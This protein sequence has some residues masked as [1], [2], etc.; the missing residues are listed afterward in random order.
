MHE[1]K[2]VFN[3]AIS[4]VSRHL[5]DQCVEKFEGDRRTKILPCWQQFLV[6]VFGQLGKRESLRDLC[7][8]LHA[9]QK[10]LYH[11]GLSNH[12]KRITLRDANEY[13]DYRIHETFAYILIARARKLYIDDKEFDLEL[14]GV[15]YAL[16]STT[17]ELCLSL[18]PWAK[19]RT[20][21]SGIKLHTLIDFRGN[22]PA[23]IHITPANVSDVKVLDVMLFEPGAFYIVDRGYLDFARLY[24]IHKAGGFFVTRAKRNTKMKRLYSNPPSDG[25][26]KQ[27][28]RCDQIVLLT[29]QK[30]KKDYPEKLRR[31]K[32]FDAKQQ[33]YYVFL[34]NNFILPAQVIADLYRY[35]WQ[36]E[37]FFKW[38]K[39]HLKI[40]TFWGYSENTVKT[41]IWIAVATYAL[42]AMIKKKL[43]IQHSMYEI[44]QILSISLFD[45]MP[46]ESLFAKHDNKLHHDDSEN[47]LQLTIF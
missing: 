39:Q 38:I 2:Y 25:E 13:R 33:R 6:M 19:F 10:K 32:Y 18:F 42:V 43:S 1:G 28:I 37:L 45:K 29:G 16:D 9:H 23:F 14:S 20:T 11:L 27:G 31:I 40:Q 17:I 3:Q 4:F 35:R 46:L 15:A 7:I 44:L 21:K 12:I 26:K 47:Q 41:Q 22:I 5:F 36:V 34:T 24:K 8:C 30:S